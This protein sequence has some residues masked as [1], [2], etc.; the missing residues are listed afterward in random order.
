MNDVLT[1]AAPVRP[2]DRHL[3]FSPNISTNG[4]ISHDTVLFFLQ[5]LA[6]TK[7]CVLVLWKEYW[8]DR[9]SDG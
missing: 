6:Q 9:Q 7:P 3:L 2:P 1:A 5:R 4:T 8:A